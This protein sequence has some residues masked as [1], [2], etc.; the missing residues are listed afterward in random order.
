MKCYEIAELK[1]Q[2]E[3]CYP[4]TMR[5]SEPYC[6][7]QI[8]GKPDMKICISKEKI[9]EY[10]KEHRQLDEDGW[11]YMM[12]GS[13]F[14]HHLVDYDG[15]ML[16]AS[17]VV[18]DGY[19]YLFSADSGIGKSTHTSLWKQYLGE[20]AFIINDDKP[21]IRKI[22][23]EYNVFGTPWSGKTD[24]N[25]NT[26]ARLGGIAF[27]Q[28][29][30]VNWIRRIEPDAA[31]LLLMRQTIRKLKADQM[32]HFIQMI[33]EMLCCIPVYELGC[34]MSEEAVRLSY[35]TMRQGIVNGKGENLK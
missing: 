19:A 16:H 6:I 21:A 18:A 2:M 15:M 5:Q 10:A 9:E 29:S 34:N 28:R 20:R 23:G 31:F 30:P 25:V 14:Y 33:R 4:R 27:L 35:E 1:V 8:E 11:E 7:K 32:D 13:R 24:Q 3:C 17:A 26:K 22:N 12:T